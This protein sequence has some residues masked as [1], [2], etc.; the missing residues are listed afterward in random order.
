MCKKREK[1]RDF[2]G[3]RRRKFI[4]EGKGGESKKQ[5]RR[6]VGEWRAR[7]GFCIIGS[8][9]AHKVTSS[10]GPDFD[11]FFL[12]S[13]DNGHRSLKKLSKTLRWRMDDGDQRD[14]TQDLK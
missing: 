10:Q 14:G 1:A 4:P 11:F 8:A 6:R 2:F 9:R 3:G 7:G 5:R 13:N 12:L